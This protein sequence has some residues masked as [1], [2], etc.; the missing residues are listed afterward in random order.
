MAR[1][2]P[3]D[4]FLSRVEKPDGDEGCWSWNGSKND[5]KKRGNFH[6]TTQRWLLAH[7]AAKLLLHEEERPEGME[8]HH[9]CLNSW[10]VNPNHIQFLTK[11]EH[12]AEHRRLKELEVV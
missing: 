9:T 11:T 1:L 4:R 2:S 10:C 8:G 3:K 12:R 5:D 6:L 7:L